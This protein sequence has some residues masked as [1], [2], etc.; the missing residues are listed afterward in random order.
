MDRLGAEQGDLAGAQAP[1]AGRLEPVVDRVLPLAEAAEAE[2][3][4]TLSVRVG[5][6][7]MDSTSKPKCAAAISR[8]LV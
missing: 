7:R 1:A 2:V 5:I 8:I 6:T 3:F 4:G